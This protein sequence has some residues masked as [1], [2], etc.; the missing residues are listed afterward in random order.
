MK[1]GGMRNAVVEAAKMETTYSSEI[2]VSF[3]QNVVA[4][5]KTII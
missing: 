4:V 2:L 3:Y 5:Q 1:E